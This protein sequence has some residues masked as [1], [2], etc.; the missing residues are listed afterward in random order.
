MNEPL[1]TNSCRLNNFGHV[2]ICLHVCI[3]MCIRQWLSQTGQGAMPPNPGK[4]G[5]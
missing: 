1:F 2:C 4:L 5:G 3:Y